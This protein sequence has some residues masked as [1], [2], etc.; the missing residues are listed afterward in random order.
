MFE[1]VIVT[2]WAKRTEL[3]SWCHLGSWRT[4]LDSSKAFKS[5]TWDS[6]IT[7]EQNIWMRLTEQVTNFVM[8]FDPMGST[9]GRQKLVGRAPDANFKWS[10]GN[11]VPI[12]PVKRRPRET[13]KLNLVS[14]SLVL[15]GFITTNNLPNDNRQMNAGLKRLKPKTRP[16]AEKQVGLDL[17]SHSLMMK[18][19]RNNRS[20]AE[21]I[22]KKSPFTKSTKL[23]DT[24]KPMK[25]KFILPWAERDLIDS[26]FSNKISKATL[27]KHVF[28][29]LLGNRSK[30]LTYQG[31]TALQVA[32]EET[33]QHTL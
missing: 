2:S 33:K 23:T 8:G 13:L 30:Q 7:T 22:N 28:R 31:L 3:E 16:A 25:C 27:E 24:A 1:V 5:K 17:Q 11:V 12:I 6:M 26:K 19:P 32:L 21:I 4:F 18:L 20:A 10:T 14:F 15:T 9:N 29:A